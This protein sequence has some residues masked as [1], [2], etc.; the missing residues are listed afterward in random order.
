MATPPTQ[1]EDASHHRHVDGICPETSRLEKVLPK[2]KGL[3]FDCDGTLLDTMPIY[4]ESWKRACDEVGLIFPV[5]R[6]YQYAGRP[7]GDIFQT[8]I[9]EQLGDTGDVA[10]RDGISS[11]RDEKPA[12]VTAAYCESVKRRHHDDVEKEGRLAGK[13]DVVVDVA[14]RYH[15]KIPMAVASSGWRDHVLGGLERAG[16]LHLFDEVVTACDDDVERPKPSPDIFL[17]A[18]DRLGVKPGECVGFEDADLGMKAL[19]AAGY[20]YASDV[21]LLHMYPRNIE[22]RASSRMDSLDTASD[23]S[24]PP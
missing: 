12:R 3:V 24:S 8:L 22:R 18:A 9:D 19:M 20:M 14:F 2:A 17:V 23:N 7:V 11:G 16:I 10:G 13:I 1:R 5:E 21:R 6:F 4:Y 15:G